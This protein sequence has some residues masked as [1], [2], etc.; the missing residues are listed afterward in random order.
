M[1][2]ALVDYIRK[3]RQYRRTYNELAKLSTKE[4]R[5]IGIDRYMI[6][7]IASESAYGKDEA[8]A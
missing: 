2:K 7:R 4:L 8:N 3:Q 5:D 1:L 6:S